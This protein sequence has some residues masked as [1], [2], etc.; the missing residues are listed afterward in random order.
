MDPFDLSDYRILIVDGNADSRTLT[1]QL[2]SDAGATQILE[3]ATGQEAVKMLAGKPHIILTDI[4]TGPVSGIDLLKHIRALPNALK[5]IVVVVFTAKND[6]DAVSR[7]L[8]CNAD[9]YI[10]KP[11]T[12][13]SFRVL[14]AKSIRRNW[15]TRCSRT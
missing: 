12:P 13:A 11:V 3:T 8:G 4:E 5:N 7:A 9:G 14:C 10:I 1:R 2:L 6:A 15:H